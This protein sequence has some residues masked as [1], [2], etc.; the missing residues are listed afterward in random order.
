MPYLGTL[1]GR[2][3]SSR[4][5]IDNA[6][7]NNAS[8]Q[9]AT[10]SVCPPGDG[11]CD[12]LW[13]KLSVQHQGKYDNFSVA[14]DRYGIL[15]EHHHKGFVIFQ[16]MEACISQK[17]LAF[18]WRSPNKLWKREKVRLLWILF[19]KLAVISVLLSLKNQR[20][21]IAQAYGTQC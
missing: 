16:T 6:M 10:V 5:Q 14:D 21:N 18:V 13:V 15:S 1:F 17:I 12:R 7:K 8:N 19:Q 20:S 2:R 3:Y 11:V 4:K 9:R